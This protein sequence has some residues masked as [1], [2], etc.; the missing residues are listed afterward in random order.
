[1]SFDP[2]AACAGDILAFRGIAARRET[3]GSVAILGHTDP[4]G[5]ALGSNLALAQIIRMRWPDKRVT[6]LLADDAPIPGAYRELPGADGLVCASAYTDAPD[7]FIGVDTPNA[8]RLAN[9]AAVLG[10]AERAV[11]LDH[12][13]S[14]S[15]LADLGV[16]RTSAAS[17]GDV[18][19]DFMRYLGVEPTCDVATCL[20]C[21][22][23]TDTGRYQYQNTDAHALRASAD[24]IDAGASP[25]QVAQW[26][27]QSA[28]IGSM[29]LKALA[30]ERL[31][32]S[33]AGDV[34]YSYVT[35]ADLERL[36]ATPEDCDSLIDVVRTVGGVAGCVFLRE[37]ADG[38]VRANLRAKVDWLDVASVA[39]RFGGG[40]HRAAAG[41]TYPGAMEDAVRD[42][43]A[44][45]QDA[46][47]ASRE[48]AGGERP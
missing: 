10:R 2:L 22:I 36:G 37:R 45:V 47:G 41:M 15:P 46:V 19:F 33:E 5:D 11:Y 48:V 9:A 38:G 42:V 29:H 32:L 13:P 34:A 39:A 16:T 6:S 17:V 23:L 26:V 1:M 25:A 7:L 28:T 3:A 21:A 44:A 8:D 27:Y 14:T 40:G 4:D 20:L 43:V 31:A 12:H 18:V 24:L 35:C 30:M